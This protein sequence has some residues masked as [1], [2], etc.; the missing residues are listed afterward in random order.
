MLNPWGTK[1]LPWCHRRVEEATTSVRRTYRFDHESRIACRKVSIACRQTYFLKVDLVS[2]TY[3]PSLSVWIYCI[4]GSL[5]FSFNMN[6]DTNELLQELLLMRCPETSIAGT[7][8]QFKSTS[9]SVHDDLDYDKGNS[10]HP[11]TLIRLPPPKPFPNQHHRRPPPPPSPPPPTVTTS[12][13]NINTSSL[14]KNYEQDSMREF[15]IAEN[16]NHIIKKKIEEMTK[17]VYEC[18]TSA[19]HVNSTLEVEKAKLQELDLSMSTSS[20]DG[21]SSCGDSTSADKKIEMR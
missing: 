6:Q 2:G 10:K 12:S 9:E 13:I 11:S 4:L 5:P 15:I 18:E 3:Q 7:R 21:T 19:T 16:N 8:E 17:Q 1:S 14:V 20:R